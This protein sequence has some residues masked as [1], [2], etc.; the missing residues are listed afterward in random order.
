MDSASATSFLRWPSTTAVLVTSTA[1][2]TATLLVL[3]RATLWPRRQKVLRGPLRTV[4]PRAS[5]AELGA[6]VYQP[7]E[8]P[9]ARD[10]ETPVR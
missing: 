4:I 6:L 7:D 2:A 1:L 9:G 10:V 3:A 5:P 8:F